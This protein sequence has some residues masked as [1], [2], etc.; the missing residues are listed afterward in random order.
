MRKKLHCCSNFCKGRY[1]FDL[2][3]KK[4]SLKLTTNF[5]ATITQINSLYLDIILFCSFLRLLY[6]GFNLVLHRI[7]LKMF[8]IVY[9]HSGVLYKGVVTIQSGAMKMP[10]DFV[11]NT[12]R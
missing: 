2:L 7:T 3:F 4:Y 10:I 8:L 9:N 6:F 1:S 12:G 11:T 5:F